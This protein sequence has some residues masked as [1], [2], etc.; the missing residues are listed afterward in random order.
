MRTE[1]ASQGEADCAARRTGGQ[2][3]RA[4]DERYRRI[5]ETANEGVWVIGADFNTTFVNRKL[6]EML[7]YAVEEMLGRPVSQF[8]AEDERAGAA[9]GERPGRLGGADQ[10]ET[11]LRR[12]DGSTLWAIVSS[13][14]FFDDDGGY[15]GALAMV[16]DVTR[17]KRLEEQYRQAQKMEAVGRLAG[18]VAHDFNNLLT[19][20]N[21]YSEL[22]LEAHGPGD[23][24]RELI[25][26]L[27]AAGD[28]AAA[29]T[30]QLLAFSR[31]Q[32]VAPQTLDLNAAVADTEKLLRRLIGEDIELACRLDPGLGRVRADP[33]QVQ[34]VLLNLAVNAR[35]AMP[36]GGRLTIETRDVRLGEADVRPGS[37]ARPGRYAVLAVADTGVGMDEATRARL[38]EP[39][40]TTKGPGLGTGLGLATVYGI[41]QQSG[42]WIDVATAPGRGAAFTIYLPQADRPS[43][44]DAGTPAPAAPRPPA[45]GTVLLAEDERE[46][47]SLIGFTLRRAGYTVLE[48]ADGAEALRLCARYRGAIRLLVSD[49]VM[50]HLSGREL[51]DRLKA[52]HPD[53]RV[54]FVSGYTE[55]AVVRHGILKEEV[56]FL[57]KPFTPEALTCKVRTVLDE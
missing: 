35:D 47:R 23:P 56:A 16:T 32:L 28:R 44:A 17:W 55:D 3:A 18:G 8:L 2:D 14:P 49:V 37:G 42:G 43:A 5:V 51:A 57:P 13:S 39:F 25:E 46:V 20:I 19:V 31:H 7:G 45:T 22:L 52:L 12:K 40:F 48:A 9:G 34:Q 21:G 53:L 41:V 15:S 54:L 50:P 4:G 33:A 1:G 38:F 36:R 10:V 29:L 27:R 30:R 24:S 6:A 11:Q 26:G